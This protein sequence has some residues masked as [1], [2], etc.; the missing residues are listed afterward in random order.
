MIMSHSG[1]K[2]VDRLLRR[3]GGVYLFSRGATTAWYAYLV[4]ELVTTMLT[5]LKV[6]SVHELSVP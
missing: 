5:R 1:T 3:V 4:F 6:G 2:N